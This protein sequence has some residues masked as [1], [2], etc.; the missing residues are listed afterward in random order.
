MKRIIP[1]ILFG[2]I[3]LALLGLDLAGPQRLY[4]LLGSKACEGTVVARQPTGC[5]DADIPENY[6]VELHTDDGQVYMFPSP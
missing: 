1:W 5:S 3:A 2:A 6:L 4:G